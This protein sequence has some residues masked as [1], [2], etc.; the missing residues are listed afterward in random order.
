M[1][2]N[3]PQFQGFDFDREQGM[4]SDSII[5][6]LFVRGITLP[7]LKYNNQTDSLDIYE[8]KLSDA[9]KHYSDLL[10]RHENVQTGLITGPEDVWQFSIL[11]FI[12]A[13]IVRNADTDIRKLLD[14]YQKRQRNKD[15]E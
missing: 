12:C 10:Q 14:E 7:S 8:G 2:P 13:Q 4:G 6:F 3:I 9:I 15:N 5:N 11:I 1:P